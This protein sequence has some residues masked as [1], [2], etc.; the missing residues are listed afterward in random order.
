[1][2]RGLKNFEVHDSKNSGCLKQTVQVFNIDIKA[3]EGSEGNELVTG[4]WGKVD[5]CYIV[6]E[7][8]AELCPR[9]LWKAD[10][11]SDEVGYLGGDFQANC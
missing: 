10:F 8:V 5:H 1:M 2:G 3:G 9:A 11:I 4:K 6:A 7:T